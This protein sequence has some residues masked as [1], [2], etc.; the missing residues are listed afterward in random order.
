MCS[1]SV[2]YADFNLFAVRKA[3]SALRSSAHWT[4]PTAVI[5]LQKHSPPVHAIA[6]VIDS[7]FQIGLVCILV[8]TTNSISLPRTNRHVSI[9]PTKSGDR[10]LGLQSRWLRMLTIAENRTRRCTENFIYFPDSPD[11]SEGSDSESHIQHDR[12]NCPVIDS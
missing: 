4:R 1:L 5:S 8:T 9:L 2:R 11:G 6:R 7:P 12:V 10:N 3:V